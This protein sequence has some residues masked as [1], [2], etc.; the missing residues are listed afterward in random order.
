MASLEAQTEQDLM[1]NSISRPL[2]AL[3][4]LGIYILLIPATTPFAARASSHRC[5]NSLCWVNKLFCHG[6]LRLTVLCWNKA[7]PWDRLPI[8]RQSATT[9]TLLPTTLLERI[10]SRKVLTF[11]FTFLEGKISG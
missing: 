3:I 5:C 1:P 10:I 8:G 7:G 9:F 6:R 4:A 2:S 11:A